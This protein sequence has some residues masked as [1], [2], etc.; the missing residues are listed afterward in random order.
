MMMMRTQHEEEAERMRE[1]ERGEEA[2]GQMRTPAGG[3]Q[4]SIHPTPEKPRVFG[5]PLSLR[6]EAFSRHDCL[7]GLSRHGLLIR[8]P[9][10][11]GVE[12]T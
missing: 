4:G 5:V 6:M 3:I 11:S 2:W 1:N 12:R 8:S 9:V 7:S 10:V